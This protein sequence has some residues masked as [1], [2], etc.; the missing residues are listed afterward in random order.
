MA[1]T[2]PGGSGEA[3]GQVRRE[4]LRSPHVRALAGA[5]RRVL[6]GGAVQAGHKEGPDEFLNQNVR[7][8]KGRRV[9]RF[10]PR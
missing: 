1:Q 5:H 6:S 2:A 7:Y 10:H 4:R 9:G 3:S 8:G